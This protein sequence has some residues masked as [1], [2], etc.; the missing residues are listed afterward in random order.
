MKTK[1][2]M[3]AEEL[4]ADQDAKQAAHG[5]AVMR[6]LAAKAEAAAEDEVERKQLKEESLFRHLYNK[7]QASPN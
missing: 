7:A 4:Q 2:V 6:E 1:V 5:A 3:T